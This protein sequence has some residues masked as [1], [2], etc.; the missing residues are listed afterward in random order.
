M[1]N[2]WYENLNLVVVE[3]KIDAKFVFGQITKK[4]INNL[5]HAS[6]I[7]DCQTLISQ[8]FQVK[9]L[10]SHNFQVKMSHVYKANKCANALTRRGLTLENDFLYKKF[11]KFYFYNLCGLP[12]VFV[13]K[14][15][16]VKM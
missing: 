2:L 4:Y 9:T 12:H 15:N 5:D 13:L 8:N 16:S 14:L 11:K 6:L 3:I 7:L 10:I 1:L